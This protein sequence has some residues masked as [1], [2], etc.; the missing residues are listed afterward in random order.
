MWGQIKLPGPSANQPNVY[1]FGTGYEEI[2]QDLAKKDKHMYKHNGILHMLDRNKM[3]TLIS[4]KSV[5]THFFWHCI[6]TN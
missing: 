3:I 2:Y 4:S 5:K 1:E 6:V